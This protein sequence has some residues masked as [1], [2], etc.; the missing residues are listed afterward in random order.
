VTYDLNQ[1]WGMQ[2]NAF[3]RNGSSVFDAN[4]GGSV[5]KVCEWVTR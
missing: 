3:L 4:T 2:L 5:I 1:A